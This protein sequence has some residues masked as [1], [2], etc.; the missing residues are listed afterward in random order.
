M[1]PLVTDALWQRLE[2][3]L[4][5]PPQRRFRFPGRKPLAY[6]Q[7]LTGILFVLKTGIA[8]SR[9]PARRE[10]GCGCGKTCREYLRNAGLAGGIWTQLPAASC[11]P[12]STK[13]A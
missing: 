1:K 6:R 5:S 11:S 7:I 12:N 9:E 13:P 3:L 2:P 8:W 10:L 4:P